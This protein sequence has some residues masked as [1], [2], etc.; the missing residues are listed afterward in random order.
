MAEIIYFTAA[1]CPPCQQTIHVV[2]E[3]ASH[4]GYAMTV[5]DI[6]LDP[7]MAAQHNVTDL[8]TTLLIRD[9]DEAV[10]RVGAYAKPDL[11]AA[12]APTT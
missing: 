2:S 12:F 5:V 10:R 8:P 1:W 4:H 3:V 9:G 6:D 7:E 11:I